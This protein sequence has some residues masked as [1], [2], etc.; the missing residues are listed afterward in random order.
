MNICIVPS[1]TL[2]T[3]EDPL[4]GSKRLYLKNFDCFLQYCYLSLLILLVIC[5]ALFDVAINF[6]RYRYRL[7]SFFGPVICLILVSKFP[8]PSRILFLC[9]YRHVSLLLVCIYLLMLI[10]QYFLLLFSVHV[11]RILLLF[12]GRQ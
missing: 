4:Q 8:Y 10:Y 3:E 5:L 11:V 12:V 2:Y 1:T 7:S 6:G 9:L